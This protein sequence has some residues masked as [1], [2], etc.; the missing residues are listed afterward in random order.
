METKITENNGN[1]IAGL[2]FD[3][4]MS[5]MIYMNVIIRKYTFAAFENWI[6]KFLNRKVNSV[7]LVVVIVFA[8]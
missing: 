7:Y 5:G 2:P 1:A 6:I 4:D 3:I 8:L